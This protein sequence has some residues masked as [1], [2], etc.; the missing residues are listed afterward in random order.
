MKKIIYTFLSIIGL[1]SCNQEENI[2]PNVIG[3]WTTTNLTYEFLEN[4]NYYMLNHRNGTP[5]TPI[6]ADSSF[7]TF[8]TNTGKNQITFYQTGYRDK[9]TKKVIEQKTNFIWEYSITGE[10]MIYT[11]PFVQGELTKTE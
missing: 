8:I 5:S 4:G 11:S 6:L 2:N 9:A 3:K 10:V 7:G 1:F